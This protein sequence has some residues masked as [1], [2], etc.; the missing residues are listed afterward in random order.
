MSISARFEVTFSR[1][2]APGGTVEQELPAF[3]RER[4]TVLRLYHAMMLTLSLI[5]I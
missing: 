5:H 3:A 1:F 2:L 4:G